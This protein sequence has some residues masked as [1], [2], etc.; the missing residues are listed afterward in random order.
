MKPSVELA[1]VLLAGYVVALPG[2][3]WVL[4]D[5]R[6]IPGGVWRHSAQRPYPQWRTGMIGSYLLCGWPVYVSALLWWRGK[7]R[8]D[9]YAEW[10]EL[11]ARKR[12]RRRAAAMRVA[13]EPVVVLA[14]YEDPRARERGH[15][16]A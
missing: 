6:R 16:D 8:V 7:E 2:L 9:L 15:A 3:L 1:G 5:L 13:S 4:G 14:D 10:A 11:S 12:A